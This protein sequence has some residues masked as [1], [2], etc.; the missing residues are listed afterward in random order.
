MLLVLFPPRLG[1]VRAALEAL[2]LLPMPL[3]SFLVYHTAFSIEKGSTRNRAFD[4]SRPL[5]VSSFP[6]TGLLRSRQMIYSRRS[7][8]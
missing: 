7:R 8:P 4:P 3:S 6:Q 2:E 1:L 5:G